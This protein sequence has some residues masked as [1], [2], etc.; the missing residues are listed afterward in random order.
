MNTVETKEIEAASTTTLTEAK[1]F[2]IATAPQF[3]EAGGKLRGIMALKKKIADTFDPHI[4]WAYDAHKSL[5]AEKKSHEEPLIEAEGY[6]KRA[7][8]GYQQE[9]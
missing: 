4:K 7:M 8:L 1:A 3:A 6:V 9:Q 2:T 5:V